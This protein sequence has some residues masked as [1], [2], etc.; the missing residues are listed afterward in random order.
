MGWTIVLSLLGLL[1]IFLAVLIVRA[2]L[3]KPKAE[4]EH[5]SGSVSI[6]REKVVRDMQQ[7]LRCRTV[8]Y[9]DEALVDQAEFQ[10][11]QE[12]LPQLYP[13]IHQTCERIFLGVNGILYR[14][15]GKQ[16]GD[17]TVLM[18]HY[19]VVPVEEEQWEKPAFEGIVEDGVLWGRGTLDTKGTLCGIMEAAEQLIAEGYTPEHDLYFAFSGQEEINGPTCPA[20]VDWFEEKG[21]HP[22]MVVDEG[23]AVV[24]NVFPGVKR[25]CALIGIAE[26]GV[27]NIEFHA[28]SGGGHASM[29][30]VHTIVGELAQA[31]AEVENHP[32]PRQLTKPVREML[33]TLGRHSTF[34][35]RLLFAN[36][37]CFEGLFDAVCR[38]SGG[39]LNAMMRTTCAMTK[40][41]GSKAFNVIPPSASV[42]MNLRLLGKDTVESARSYL[43]E[44]IRNPNI[45]VTVYEG[46]NPSAESDTSCAQWNV[47]CSAVADTWTEAIVSPYLMMACSDSW[48]Y[49]RITD[50]VYKFSAMKLSKE[51]RAMIHGNNERVPVGTLV[52]TV[53]FFVRLMKKC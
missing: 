43:E 50:R 37:W 41:Q 42:G 30:P 1:V 51:E 52:R 18:A 2:L 17:P 35:F 21:I 38:K 19:D 5:F 34:A 22:A 6:D 14:W 13:H 28:K 32:F 10:K 26:K 48:H 31:V 46:R 33:D 27:A 20:M 8:S 36:L 12:L 47:L 4:P 39:E 15:S 49:C 29:P 7:M 11:F 45:D 40:M 24:E 9:N 16:Q 3:Y 53:E 23:G 44:V 25:E